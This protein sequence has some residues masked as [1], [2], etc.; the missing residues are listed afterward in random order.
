MNEFENN[1]VGEEN[2]ENNMPLQGDIT[3]EAPE[4]AEPEVDVSEITEENKPKRGLL[5]T[6]Y[7]YLET[8]CYALGLMM[9]L[10]LFVFR[11]VSVDG[12]SMETTLHDQDKLIIY[13]L[14]YTPETGDI[15]VINPES[16]K[17]DSE[18]IIKRIIATEGQKVRIDYAN[19][20]VYVDGVK[21]DEPYIEGK[22]SE[23]FPMNSLDMPN[24]P[25]YEFVIQEGKVFVMGDNR[26][27]SADSRDSVYGQ[28]DANRILGRAVIRLSPEFGFID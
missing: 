13:N 10:L 19:W 14:F 25:D 21:L 15:V 22:R 7:D 6:V 4:Q 28:I 8:F 24:D 1:P 20:A 2:A 27:G 17:P 12:S 16:N 26:N 23:G 3:E 18:P 5:E 11:M 9:L